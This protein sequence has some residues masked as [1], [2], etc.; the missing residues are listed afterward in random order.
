MEQPPPPY[1]TG[2]PGQPPP[3]GG[4]PPTGAYPQQGAPMDSKAVP[5][6]GQRTY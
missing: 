6:Q 1:T 4:Y 2:A 5:P 3:P